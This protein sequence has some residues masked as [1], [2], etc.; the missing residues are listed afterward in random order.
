MGKA[1][2]KKWKQENPRDQLTALLG[3]LMGSI[4]NGLDGTKDP[5]DVLLTVAKGLDEIESLSPWL[6]ETWDKE[7]Q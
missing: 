3:S 6:S 1:K 7:G 4:D 5:L 2:L